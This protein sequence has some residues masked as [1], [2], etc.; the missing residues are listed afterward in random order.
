MSHL[1]FLWLQASQARMMAGL[2]AWGPAF[3]DMA[4][5][6]SFAI[7]V[8]TWSSMRMRGDDAQDAYTGLTAWTLVGVK[9]I[10]YSLT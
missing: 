4:G 3:S 5:S 9:G 7:A 1:V 10:L 6:G 8:T 2:E